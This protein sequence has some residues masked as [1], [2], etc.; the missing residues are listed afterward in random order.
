MRWLYNFDME[1]FRAI[2]VDL[3]RDWLNPLFWILSYSGL[4]QVQAI[5]LICILFWKKPRSTNFLLVAAGLLAGLASTPIELTEPSQ[6]LMYA[7]WALRGIGVVLIVVGAF[8]ELKDR[9]NPLRF[10]VLPLLTTLVVAGLPIAQGVKRLFPRDRP[11]NLAF[12]VPQEDIYAKSFPSGHSTT[13]FAIAWML[14]LLTRKTEYA[15]IGQA[16]LV[17]ALLVGLS[18]VYRGVHWPTDVVAG[19]F[20]G[21]FA[22]ALVFLSIGLIGRA[23]ESTELEQSVNE[24]E[25]QTLG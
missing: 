10:Y 8:R 15:W 20:A 5:A 17:W 24:P 25:A 13:S 22:A 19:A 14:W 4:G 6:P 12:A 16:S 9:E 3:H 11:S 18:R 7:L 21:L 2:H 1:A 23:T